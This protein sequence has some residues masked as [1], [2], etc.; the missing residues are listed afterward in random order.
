MELT[1]NTIDVMSKEMYENTKKQAKELFKE[2]PEDFKSLYDVH[3]I[4]KSLI[5]FEQFEPKKN[6][7]FVVSFSKNAKIPMW[8]V[9]SLTKPSF[10]FSNEI[11]VVL[12]DPIHLSITKNLL[13]LTKDYE[14]N[15]NT[16]KLMI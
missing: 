13:A 10:P 4:K 5:P 11:N 3:D 15:G 9:K 16:F 2:L 8:V 6:N 7:R 1:G 14:L 12:Y